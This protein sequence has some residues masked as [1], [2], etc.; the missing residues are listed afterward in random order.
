MNLFPDKN[1]DIVWVEEGATREG[2][3]YP[4]EGGDERN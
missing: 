3:I 1:L 2:R 4:F